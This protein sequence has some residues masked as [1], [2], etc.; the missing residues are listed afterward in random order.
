MSDDSSRPAGEREAELA[1]AEE[2]GPAGPEWEAGASAAAG[3]AGTPASPPR[4][5][6]S[7]PPPPSVPRPAPR[8]GAGRSVAPAGPLRSPRASSNP[9]PGPAAGAE[10]P[11]P[12]P[13]PRVPGVEALAAFAQNAR[14][15]AL[16]L[17]RPGLEVPRPGRPASA[18]RR[19]R[20]RI[21]LGA[22]ANGSAPRPAS[23][24]IQAAPILQ[25]GEPAP[26][27]VADE[28]TDE[29][30][31]DDPTIVD[32]GPRVEVHSEEVD[33]EGLE[34]VEPE[35]ELAA[36]A[37]SKPAAAPAPPPA[38]P[39]TAPAADKGDDGDDEIVVVEVERELAEGAPPAPPPVSARASVPQPEPPPPPKR[40][41]PPPKR[42]AG[43][44]PAAPSEEAAPGEVPKRRARAWW[45][46]VFGDD[47]LRT[48][49]RLEP[50]IVRKE[51]DFIESS[52]GVEKGG[53]VLDLACGAGQHAVELASRGYSVVG[54]DLSLAML[55]RAADEAQ[56]R[57]QKLNFLQGDMREMAFE[58]MFDGVYCWST[59]FGYF[60]D[61]KNVAVLQRIYRALRKGGMLLLDVM[62]RDYVA[63]RQPSLVWFEGEGCM[64]M[65]EMSVDFFSSRLKVK[66]MAMFEDGRSRE[67]DYSIRLYALHELG[68]MMREVGFKVV[69]V[70]GHPAHPGVFFGSESPRLIILAERTG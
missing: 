65:D 51:V 35:H 15:E 29:R 59:S 7:R 55:A 56:D 21:P 66:R 60:E 57:N 20:R 22:Y 19:S 32:D 27:P 41:P 58:E 61:D 10:I 42:P 50:K 25:V 6:P 24:S 36:E 31:Y 23:P 1:G 2:G 53:V 14:D 33:V 16:G 47:F 70:A 52:L 28:G 54:F 40:P 63:P 64:V 37:S 13:L 48:M 8:P 38:A 49:D 9:P 67:V 18:R 45:D 68:K 46:D 30:L 34:E 69:E 44:A 17:P 39:P 3:L 12:A 43:E 5:S 62:N 26:F 11:G 4:P